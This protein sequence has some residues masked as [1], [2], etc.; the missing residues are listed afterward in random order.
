MTAKEAYTRAKQLAQAGQYEA[1]LQALI[2][3]DHPK[4]EA[5]RQQIR[6]AAARRDAKS[7]T[8]KQDEKQTKKRQLSLLPLLLVVVMDV[9]KKESAA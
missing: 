2:G 9:L 8:V 5:L 6:E 1:A 4:V 3:Y 7:G